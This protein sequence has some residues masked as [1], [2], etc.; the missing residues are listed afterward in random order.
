[1]SFDDTLAAW[2]VSL[3]LSDAEA[4]EIHRWIVATPVPSAAL[5]DPIRRTGSAAGAPTGA[6]PAPGGLAPV[7]TAVGPDGAE[8]ARPELSPRWW[9]GFTAEFTT[10]LVASTRPVHWVA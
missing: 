4:A 7:G 8:R 1:M 9:L 10:G 5:P 2:A 6:R 3:R